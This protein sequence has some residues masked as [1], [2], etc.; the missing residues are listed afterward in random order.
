MISLLNNIVASVAIALM[1]VEFFYKIGL[2][3]EEQWVKEQNKSTK[4]ALTKSGISKDSK[5]TTI[6]TKTIASK[7][8]EDFS[9]FQMITWT[10]QATP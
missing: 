7:P 6:T 8:Q 10:S 3:R 9:K 5:I 1:A 2:S 4:M